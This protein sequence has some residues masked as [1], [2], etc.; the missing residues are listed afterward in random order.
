MPSEYFPLYHTLK[1]NLKLK[2][3]TQ[4]QFSDLSDKIEKSRPDIL[5]NVILLIYEHARTNDDFNIDEGFKLVYD[6]EEIDN[7]YNLDL[8]K[9]P[10]ELFFILER[11][12]C[13]VEEK[14]L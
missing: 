1:Q 8:K 5:K 14:N 9:F 13:L 6:I 4:K 3:I 7:G 12:M 10:K 11:L 2:R